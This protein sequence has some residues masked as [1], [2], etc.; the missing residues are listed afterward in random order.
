MVP[1]KKK[2]QDLKMPVTKPVKQV[3][4]YTDGACLGNPGPGGYGAV[5][6]Y[7]TL[8]KELFGGFCLTTNNRM[9]LMGAIAALQSL[10]TICEVTLLTDSQYVVNGINKGWARRWRQRG[11]MRNKTEKAVN[12]DLWELLLNLCERHQVTF[13]WVRGHAGDPENEHCDE[14]SK[15]A[16]MAKDL[17]VDKGYLP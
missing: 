9:E 17:P 15:Q 8:R 4:I 11:W 2:E 7:G 16:A 5:L 3:K 12:P 13:V 1:L 14:L 10:K 6:L